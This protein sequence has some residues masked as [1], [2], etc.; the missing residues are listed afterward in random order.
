VLELELGEVD[1]DLE[2]EPPPE[3]EED[4]PL[5]GAAKARI[6]SSGEIPFAEELATKMASSPI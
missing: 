6:R 1:E 4:K 5:L 2:L 3:L